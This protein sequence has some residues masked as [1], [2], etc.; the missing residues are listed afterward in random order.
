MGEHGGGHSAH[1]II[2]S[3][4]TDQFGFEQAD[5]VPVALFEETNQLWF[6]HGL[7]K[8]DEIHRVEAQ[9]LHLAHRIRHA[10]VE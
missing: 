7:Q 8:L 1:I 9:F 5:D 4:Q 10:A 6:V 2:L 3:Q